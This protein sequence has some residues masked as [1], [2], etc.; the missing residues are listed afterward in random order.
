MDT[1]SDNLKVSGNIFFLYLYDVAKNADLVTIEKESFVEV[2]KTPLSPFFKYYHMPLTFDLKEEPLETNQKFILFSKIYE[3]G[4][5]SFCYKIP[6]TTTIDALKTNIID[7]DKTFGK[8]SKIE[9]YNV[10]NNIK[11]AL[12]NPRFYNIES[13]YFAIQVNPMVDTIGPDKF[14]EVYGTK[15]ASLLRL[16]KKNLSN[17]QKDQMLKSATGYYGQ[18]FIIIDGEASFIY[19]YEYFEALEFIESVNV[20]KLELNYFDKILDEELNDYYLKKSYKIPLSAH[21]PILGPRME[22]LPISKLTKMRVNI[23]FVTER[24]KN[25]VKISGDSYFIEIYELLVEKLLVKDWRDSIDKKL[26]ILK[27]IYTFY[28]DQLN[29]KS[30]QMLTMVIIILIALEAILA[31]IR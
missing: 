8:K 31:A 20:E 25:C 24:L 23:S 10:F 28:Q 1:S 4:V 6:F 22:D 26:E 30:D 17:Y 14:K 13:S 18:D 7:I 16:E 5:T 21:I 11:T 3:F 29:T 19:D 9:A 15:I 2:I 27:D 12:K